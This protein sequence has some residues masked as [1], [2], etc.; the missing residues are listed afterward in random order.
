MLTCGLMTHVKNFTN[1]SYILEIVLIYY[2]KCEIFI[3]FSINS[4]H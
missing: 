2:S 3:F 1:R 4:Y